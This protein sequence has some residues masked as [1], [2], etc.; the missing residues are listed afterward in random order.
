[1]LKNQRET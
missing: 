1:M